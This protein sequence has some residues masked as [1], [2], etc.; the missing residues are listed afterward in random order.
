MISGGDKVSERSRLAVEDAIDSSATCP[1]LP[2]GLVKRRTARSR[3]SSPVRGAGVR[4][5]VLRR[6]SAA[7][8][9][10]SATPTGSSC[11]CWRRPRAPPRPGPL[12]HP[13]ARRRRPPP[14]PPRRRRAAGADHARGVPWSSAAR[15][16]ASATDGPVDGFVDVDNVQGAALAVSH[17]VATGRQ[18][19]RDDRRR[20]T[21]WQVAPLRGT[22]PGSPGRTRR[23]TRLVEHG[24]FG[25][26]SGG[27]AMRTLL[28]RAPDVDAVF[29]ANDLMAVGA[30]ACARPAGRCRATWPWSA[31]RGRSGR[32]DD[33]PGAHTV[34]VPEGDGPRDGR[35]AAGRRSPTRAPTRDGCSRP[36]WLSAT[37][38]A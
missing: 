13:A 3:S 24:D 34:L 28:A 21:W 32:P 31:S 9:Q 11:W 12:P 19:V 4:R 22:P 38:L 15:P 7:S 18:R 16:A 35:P 25:R 6:W 17:L 36:V 20:R 5:A 10:P 2:P 1:T 8:G 37:A 27:H 26:D 29:C 14:L 33:R 30:C 23:S